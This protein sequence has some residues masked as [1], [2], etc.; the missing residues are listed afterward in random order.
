MQS[1][2]RNEKRFF[3]KAQVRHL[4]VPL[5][6]ELSLSRIWPQAALLPDFLGYMPKEY[7]S[8]SKKT[9]RNFFWAVLI[10]LANDFVEQLIIDC[11][12][13]RLRAAQDRDL[14]P[15]A[16]NIAPNWVGPLLAQPFVSCKYVN[17][18]F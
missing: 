10:T 4:R 6:Q 17:I 9:D 11:R 18:F 3:W 5:W 16:I 12:E 1:I 14:A 13:Q 15:R 8:T 2:L 7:S